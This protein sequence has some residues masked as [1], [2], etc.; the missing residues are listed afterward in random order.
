VGLS[1]WLFHIADKWTFATV[2]DS[3]MESACTQSNKKV[4]CADIL[5]C[6]GI[7]YRGIFDSGRM[8]RGAFNLD[9]SRQCAARISGCISDQFC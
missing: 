4:V 2:V 1:V 3:T 8:E 7:N 6:G 9:N 5:V